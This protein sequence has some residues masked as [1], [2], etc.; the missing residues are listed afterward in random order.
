M[1]NLYTIILLCLIFTCTVSGQVKNIK[2]PKEFVGGW[3]MKPNDCEITYFIEIYYS[4]NKLQVSGYEWFS[5]KV[6]LEKDKDF[7][8]FLIEGIDADREK[9]KFKLKMKLD[10][11]GKLILDNNS[12]EICCGEP[13][14]TNKLI[15]CK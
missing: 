6:V 11:T 4:N 7:Y 15:R 8:V 10:K 5:N 3:A 13:T 1:K 2:L 12:Y 14:G 9:F